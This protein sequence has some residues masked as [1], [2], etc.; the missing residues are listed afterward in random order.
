MA[1]LLHLQAEL[2]L[3][4]VADLELLLWQVLLV[5]EGLG[6]QLPLTSAVHPLCLKVILELVQLD[7]NTHQAL[8]RF[9]SRHCKTARSDPLARPL[10]RPVALA[11]AQ[12][13]PGSAALSSSAMFD[14]R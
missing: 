8:L 12:F 13:S 11:S 2:L 1:L 10:S 3:L 6:L 7:L 14:R 9:S 5:V 4:M